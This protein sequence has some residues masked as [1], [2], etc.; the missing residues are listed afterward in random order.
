MMSKRRILIIVFSLFLAI[1]A[2]I[3]LPAIYTTRET[4]SGKDAPKE[5]F[6]K[7]VNDPIEEQEY[8]QCAAYAAAYVM[9]FCGDE[10]HGKELYPV[11]HRT[12]GAVLPS[13]VVKLF[14]NHNYEAK[15]YHGTLDTMKE[16][17]SQGTPI[18]V[19][20]RIPNDTHYAVVTGYDEN[21]IYLADP[22][23]E[24]A[25]ADER[26]YNRIV[27]NEEFK[28]LWKTGF[29]IADNVYITAEKNAVP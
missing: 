9:R 2:I 11:L 21:N 4:V 13:N 23:T 3:V 22:M 5:D 16:R 29:P 7:T 26:S 8:G 17:L 18:I 14:R 15:A 25:N 10:I 28:K 24:N 19:Y 12:F 1:T 20:L 6:I 27:S